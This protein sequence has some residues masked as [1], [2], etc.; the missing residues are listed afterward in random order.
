MGYPDTEDDEIQVY[1]ELGT[2]RHEFLSLVEKSLMDGISGDYVGLLAYEIAEDV[3]KDVAECADIK[4]WNTCDVSLGVGR[5][6]LRALG[7][8]V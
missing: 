3:A 2:D 1:N 8:D 6:L 4:N 5:V 7:V